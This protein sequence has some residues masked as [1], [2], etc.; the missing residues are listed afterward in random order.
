MNV[1][2]IRELGRLVRDAATNLQP[3][4]MRNLLGSITIPLTVGP[5]GA[6][7]SH[8]FIN[9]LLHLSLTH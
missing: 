7:I 5:L 2:G 8:G 4:E 6:S 1:K 3:N 9:D